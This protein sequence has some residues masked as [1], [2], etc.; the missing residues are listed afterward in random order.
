MG[1]ATSAATAPHYVWGGA[2]DGWRL[3]DEPALSV[4]EE[5][6]PPGTAETPHRHARATQV[7]YVLDGE[8]TL[9]CDGTATTLPTGVALTVPPSTPH[10]ARN[11]GT[12]A[13]RFLVISAPSTR[14][15]REEMA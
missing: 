15:D 9:D 8:L 3:C 6:M 7:F 11:L 10:Q 5:R 2:C 1:S 12:V 13:A 14:G 4:I